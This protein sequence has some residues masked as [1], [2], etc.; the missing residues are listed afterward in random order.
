MVH[1]SWSKVQEGFTVP[2]L[3]HIEADSNPYQYAFKMSSI[4]TPDSKQSEAYIAT[5]AL[6]AIFS[7][8]KED[9]VFMRLPS[10]WK[11]LWSELA[12]EKKNQEDAADREAVRKLRAIVRQKHDRELEDGVLLQGAFRGRGSQRNQNESSDE[13]A[14]ERLGRNAPGPEYYQK[15]WAD[16]S[17]TSRFQTM[18]VRP[19]QPTFVREDSSLRSN[20]F[21]AAISNATPDV[22]IS[23][24]GFRRCGEAAS[25]HCLW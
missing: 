23:G 25:C 13:A 10:T 2:S 1:I 20:T 8:T 18:L 9:K 12:E 15:I 19:V 16:K 14:V 5:V 4:A 7:S 6:F 21:L 11:D 22:A 3:P 24:P 17:R